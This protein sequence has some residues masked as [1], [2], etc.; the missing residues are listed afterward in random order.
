[1]RLLV[2]GSVAL[3]SVKTPFG[4]VKNALGGSAVYA[5]YS[6]SFFTGVDL[7]GVAGRDFPQEYL[8]L[9]KER[10]IDLTGLQIKKGKTFSWSGE[11]ASN[12][13]QCQTLSTCLNLFES[14]KPEIPSQ[15]SDDKFAFLGNI[16]PE[17]QLMVYKQLKNPQLLAADSMNFWIQ[18]KKKE[19][20]SLLKHIDLFLLNDSEARG[21]SNEYNL[22]AAAK[23]VLFLGPKIF[24]VKKGEH[25]VI[26]FLKDGS[27]FSLPAYPLETIAD[28]T[29][30]GDVFGGALMGYL[31]RC[32]KLNKTNIYQGIIWGSIMASYNVEGFS[33][34]RLRSLK[35]KDLKKRYQD[36][37]KIRRV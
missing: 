4:E 36:F 35:D 25:G 33:L 11:Y 15:Y 6:A 1:M 18:R 21:F 8:K 27:F 19:L 5:S 10:N 29:G 37:K 26:A 17:L 31:A 7:V 30:A 12:L 13:N 2:V 22:R 32:A 20:I 24:V 3:D 9:L 23:Y 28:P 34:N 14:F 16:D